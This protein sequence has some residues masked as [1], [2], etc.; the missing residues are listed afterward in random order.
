LKYYKYHCDQVRIST[1]YKNYVHSFHRMMSQDDMDKNNRVEEEDPVDKI[2]GSQDPS[3]V[4]AFEAYSMRNHQHSNNSNINNTKQKAVTNSTSNPVRFVQ[5]AARKF[6]LT[7]LSSELEKIR[8]SGSHFIS[9]THM[10]RYSSILQ[11]DC[12]RLYMAVCL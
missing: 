7:V 1:R 12:L 8:Y 2:V 11:L 6:G 3:S 10:E 4:S 5:E 9:L